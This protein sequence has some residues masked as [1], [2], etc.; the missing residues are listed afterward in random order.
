MFA[1]QH[2]LQC[3]KILLMIHR[4][5][6]KLSYDKTWLFHLLKKIAC[7]KDI[8]IIWYHCTLNFKYL[9]NVHTF[10]KYQLWYCC[11]HIPLKHKSNVFTFISDEKVLLS[12]IILHLHQGGITHQR[13]RTQKRR[14]YTHIAT[15]IFWNWQV[16]NLPLNMQFQYKVT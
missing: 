1:V 15:I 7:N 13:N 9:S 3:I 5:I 12:D 10:I 2:K 8:V 14:I 4:V 16:S 6:Y 11:C